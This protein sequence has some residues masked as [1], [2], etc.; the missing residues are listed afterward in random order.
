MSWVDGEAVE[1]LDRGRWRKTFV[2]CHETTTAP[3]GWLLV[4]GIP[5]R[6][7]P[8]AVRVEDVRAALAAARK[9]TP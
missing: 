2:D 5:S 1:V 4:S 3:F 8:F 6:A 9:E 7:G